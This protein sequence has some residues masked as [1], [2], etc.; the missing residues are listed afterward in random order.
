MKLSYIITILGKVKPSYVYIET[1]FSVSLPPQSQSQAV[2]CVGTSRKYPQSEY[3]L[4]VYEIHS[5]F[6]FCFQIE[7]YLFEHELLCSLPVLVLV[8]GEMGGEILL[9]F[10]RF[11]YI[12]VSACLAC[13]TIL[14]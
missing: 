12:L 11:C 4:V 10:N 6:N 14:L 13:F 5:K 9:R 1:Y 7:D 2:V 8:Q 3:F